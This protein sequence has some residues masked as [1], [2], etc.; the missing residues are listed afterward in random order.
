M[1][2]APLVLLPVLLGFCG[3]LIVAVRGVQDL[4]E[5]AQPSWRRG[6]CSFF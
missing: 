2:H 1:L 6:Y 3:R 4:A 5:S